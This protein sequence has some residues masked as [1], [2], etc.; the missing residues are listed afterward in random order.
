MKKRPLAVTFLAVIAVIAGLVAIFDVLRYLGLF[1]V[2]QFGQLQF[3]GT[4]IFGAILAGIVAVIWFGV[5][6]QL[7]A[8]D[9]RGWLFVVVIAVFNLIMLGLA[10][11]GNTTFQAVLLPMI[12]NVVALILG[13]L[14]STKEAFGQA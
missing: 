3:F 2:A 7:W 12:V 6:R 4:S 11:L 10:I 9:P 14:P 5:A 1:P 8:L 13:L